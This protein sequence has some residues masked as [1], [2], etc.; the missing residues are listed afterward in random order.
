M[1]LRI[2]PT[3]P[4]ARVAAGTA[5]LARRLAADRRGAVAIM[6]ALSFLV[7]LGMLGIAIDFARGQLF[8]SKVYYASDAVALAM[9]REDFQTI[10]AVELQRRAQIYFDANLPP[11]YMGGTTSLKVATTGTPPTVQSFSLT[12]D[13]TLPLVFANLIAQLG[14]PTVGTV[15][16]SKTSTAQFTRQTSNKG[17][18]EIVIVLD[19]SSSMSGSQN[20]LKTAAKALIDMLFEDQETRPNLYM[21]MVHYQGFVNVLEKAVKTKTDV[22]KSWK[23]GAP[24][25]TR[26][27]VNDSLTNNY[28]LRNVVPTSYSKF[29]PTQNTKNPIDI[30]D[31]STPGES[32]A[33]TSKRSEVVAALN[34]YVA[35]GNTMIGEGLVWGWRMLSP[36]WRKIWKT[37]PPDDLPLDY[38][39][40]YMKKIIVLMTDGL[41]VGG[42]AN[43][44]AYHDTPSTSSLDKDLLAICTA[45]KND[46]IQIY[47]IT[48]GS[49]PNKT[50]MQSCATAPGM[51][52]HAALPQ[53]LKAAFTQVGTDLTTMKLIR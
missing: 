15:G 12:V 30:C 2:P 33:L 49:G 32:I 13:A 6:V 44:N 28:H 3:F 51:Y 16:I 43:S 37:T 35:D 21:G 46:T 27:T 7:M 10:T 45:A 5:V 36:A 40:P 42:P 25:C 17:G 4:P 11:G 34:S 9:A 48:Y 29:D 19:N 53:D 38:N 31:S 41:N 1:P 52:F 26:A 50:L 20:A 18:M 22:V 24:N 47:T 14:G 39:T 8:S 23:T